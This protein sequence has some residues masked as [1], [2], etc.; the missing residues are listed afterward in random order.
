MSPLSAVAFLGAAV[1]I[2]GWLIWITNALMDLREWAEAVGEDIDE[3]VDKVN[4]VINHLHESEPV[5]GR[6]AEARRYSFA[7]N[8]PVAVPGV[9]GHQDGTENGSQRRSEA[10]MTTGRDGGAHGE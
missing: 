2:V 8:R 10:G 5:T 9:Q 6:H 4:G 3:A 1:L 7:L